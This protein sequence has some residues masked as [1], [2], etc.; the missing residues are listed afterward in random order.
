MTKTEL[1]TL[2]VDFVNSRQNTV[3]DEWRCT[4]RTLVFGVMIDFAKFLELKKPI[5]MS[6]IQN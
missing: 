5:T 1:A 3:M 6:D 4:D 2:M